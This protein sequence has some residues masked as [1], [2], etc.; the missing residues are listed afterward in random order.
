[1]NYRIIKTRIIAFIDAVI[2]HDLPTHS[3]ASAYY[4]VLTLAPIMASVVLL[5]SFLPF[6]SFQPLLDQIQRLAG[7]Q[8][9]S[10]VQLTVEQI[11]TPNFR[12]MMGLFTIVTFLFLGSTLFAQ[13]KSSLNII[14][15][16]EQIPLKKWI[17]KRLFMII[18]LFY[19][20][21]FLVLGSVSLSVFKFLESFTG[22]IVLPFVPLLE[23][24]LL[25]GAT[26][27]LYRYLPDI[28]LSWMPV[29]KGSITAVFLFILGK[30]IFK[31][32]IEIFA[33][34]SVY[35]T[36]NTLFIFLVWVY[37][38]AFIFFLGAELAY[39]LGAKPGRKQ[40]N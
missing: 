9:A 23:I 34:G 18:F 27:A 2:V 4:A 36:A 6:S 32:Y 19:F 26:A 30:K 31:S 22:I 15:R 5:S 35:G 33:I 29:L 40:L 13:L 12:T 37:Y 1:M 38:S 3:A 39:F 16:T 14:F 21:L 10:T 20:F 17:L 8:I 25:V 11:Q 28:R 24:V 7:A